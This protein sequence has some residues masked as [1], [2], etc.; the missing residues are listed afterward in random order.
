MPLHKTSEQLTQELALWLIPGNNQRRV[1][2]SYLATTGLPDLSLVTAE[3]LLELLARNPAFSE[4]TRSLASLALHNPWQLPFADLLKKHLLW[5]EEDNHWLIFLSELPNL[6]QQLA[7]PPLLL[8]VVGQPEQLH[9]PSL[10]IVGSRK[11]SP[12]GQHHAASWSYQL[13]WQGLNIVSGLARGVD[14][15]AHKGALRAVTEGASGSTCAVLAHG[16]DTVYPPEHKAMAANISEAGALISEYP[17]GTPPMPRYFPARNRIV[18]GLSLGVV[19][20]EATLRSGSLVSARHAMEQGR[21]VMAIPGSIR[22]RHN[23]GCHQL[24][25]QGAALVTCPEEVL[26]EL[27]VPLK[28]FLPDENIITVQ[29]PE[30]LQSIYCLVSDLPIS[31]DELLARCGLTAEQGAVLLLE[32]ELEGLI[33]QKPGGWCKSA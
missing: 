7:D 23:E 32:L 14:S 17:L 29:V 21:E 1:I 27:S 30:H 33:M 22:Y 3:I 28:S 18:T 9:A 8:C 11:L 6:L 25:R 31:A 20:V 13:A 26:N 4:K 2:K 16:L 19:V 5:A 12:E 15:H 24:I 10:A